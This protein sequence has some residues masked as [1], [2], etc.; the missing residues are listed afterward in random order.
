MRGTQLHLLCAEDE[1]SGGD[2]ESATGELAVARKHFYRLIEGGLDT[3]F[4]SFSHPV[5]NSSSSSTRDSQSEDC[6]SQQ[7][8]FN[9]LLSPTCFSSSSHSSTQAEQAAAIAARAD[10]AASELSVHPGQLQA[11]MSHVERKLLTNFSQPRHFSSEKVGSHKREEHDESAEREVSPEKHPVEPG[12]IQRKRLLLPGALLPLA[13]DDTVVILQE[14]SFL[15]GVGKKR[16]ARAE[17]GEGQNSCTQEADDQQK[18]V[19]FNKF[20]DVLQEHLYG[21]KLLVRKTSVRQTARGESTLLVDR[22]GK[23]LCCM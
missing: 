6:R 9:A 10:A 15:S 22:A 8:S 12:V 7:K 17:K 19:E 16:T 21:G 2:H 18:D 4:S 5:E 1:E 20:L 13:L 11:V 3:Q 14:G 23:C